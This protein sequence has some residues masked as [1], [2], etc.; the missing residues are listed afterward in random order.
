MRLPRLILVFGHAL[1]AL[2]VFTGCGRTVTGSAAQ[3]PD[4]PG[5]SIT[6][7]GFG[8]IAGRP[9]A[10]AQIEVYTEPQC[11]HCAHLQDTDGPE[12]KGL[13]ALGLLTVTYRPVTFLDTDY[14]YSAKVAGALFL[15]AA[16]GTSA[17]ALQAYVQT[18]WGHQNPG[19]SPP[20]DGQLAGWAT[21]SGVSSDAVAAIQSGQRALNTDDMTSANEARLQQIRG[22]DAGTPT[23]FDLGGNAVV[24]IQEAG[25]LAKLIGGQQTA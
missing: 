5:V 22:G 25:W 19:G 24:D 21:D 15:A 18:L 8:I 13:I 4:V 7:D 10:P 20:S 1:V 3:D 2:L 16:H 23:V 14:P 6:A 12:M 9:D 17:P 11:T